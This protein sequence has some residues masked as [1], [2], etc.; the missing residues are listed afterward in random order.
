MVV[1][2]HY[3]GHAAGRRA[4]LL[5][6]R[7]CYSAFYLYAFLNK[8]SFMKR[9]ETLKTLTV[10]SI[11]VLVGFLVFDAEWLLWIAII[12]LTGAALETAVTSALAKYWMKFAEILGSI[13][14]KVILSVIFYVILTPIA[15]L[16]RFSHK[17]V[18]HRFLGTE[19]ESYFDDKRS[20]YDRKSFEKPW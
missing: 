6:R 5:D 17:T 7:L 16:Y 9:I 12:L 1:I 8:R 10:L 14:S 11:A 2:A 13:N 18:V 20:T 4:D 19:R 3:C 15:L